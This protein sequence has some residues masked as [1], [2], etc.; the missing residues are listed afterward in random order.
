MPTIAELLQAY[1][2]STGDSLRDIQR[3]SNGVLTSQNVAKIRTVPRK[4][5][6]DPR[7]AEALSDLLQVSVTT[8]VLAY[9]AS[10][11]LPVVQGGSTLETMLPPG[12]DSLTPEDRDA[13]RAITRQ[14]IDARRE[15]ARPPAPDLSRAEDFRLAEPGTLQPVQEPRGPNDDR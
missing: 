13:I 9:A 3:R 2:D 6:P 5:F 1:M 7:T 15:D 4:A 8:I 10:L 12:T 14:L 11:G